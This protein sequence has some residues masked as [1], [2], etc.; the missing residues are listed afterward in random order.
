MPSMICCGPTLDTR[1]TF[2]ARRQVVV[3]SP[4]IGIGVSAQPIAAGDT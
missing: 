2:Q 4:E 1:L 3:D